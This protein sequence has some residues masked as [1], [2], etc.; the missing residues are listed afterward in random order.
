MCEIFNNMYNKI[1][2]QH[3]FNCLIHKH[4]ILKISE[5][6]IYQRDMLI[7]RKYFNELKKY[8]LKRKRDRDIIKIMKNKRKYKLLSLIFSKWLR[9]VMR[10]L[11]NKRNNN[12]I[13]KLSV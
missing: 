9:Y 8:Y 10:S 11:I 13:E 4:R 12:D 1:F 2:Q 6:R 5:N 7:K 3:F